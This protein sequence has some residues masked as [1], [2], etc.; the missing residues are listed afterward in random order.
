VSSMPCTPCLV[1]VGALVPSAGGNPPRPIPQ[2]R[3]GELPPHC[4]CTCRV[5]WRGG[6]GPR[7]HQL[8]WRRQAALHDFGLLSTKGRRSPQETQAVRWAAPQ[9]LRIDS[10]NVSAAAT[11]LELFYH[12]PWA[13]LDGGVN[14]V[15]GA[16]LP[17][18]YP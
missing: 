10:A 2:V 6:G 9:Q 15:N 16:N 7:H 1:P 3:S 4:R 12:G 5:L 14:G 8:V 18:I 17:L 13:C 11:D